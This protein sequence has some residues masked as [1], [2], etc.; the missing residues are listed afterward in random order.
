MSERAFRQISWAITKRCFLVCRHCMVEASPEGPSVS[1][2]DASRIIRHLPAD[3]VYNLEITGGDPFADYLL[4]V[5]I[6]ERLGRKM[7]TRRVT[8][9]TTGQWAHDEDETRTK[10]ERLKELGA[11]GVDFL[12]EDEFHFE[13][14]LIRRNYD[15]AVTVAAEVFGPK[16]A[17]VRKPDLSDGII[18]IGRGADPSLKEYWGK[19]RCNVRTADLD[20]DMQLHITHTGDAFV[21]DNEVAPSLGSIVESS[22]EQLM[23]IARQD[24]WQQALLAAGPIGLARAEGLDENLWS[25]R[26]DEVGECR[27]CVELFRCLRGE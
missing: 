9:H 26:V 5:W 18:P 6:L 17:F 14:G 3:G 19:S 23:D 16:G 24:A 25:A 7:S 10:L 13:A 20:T 12:C 1:E 11:D 15:R 8:V 21:C 22:Y 4:L 27:T 2:G